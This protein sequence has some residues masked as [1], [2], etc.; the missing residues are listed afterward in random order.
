MIKLGGKLCS[1][2][3]CIEQVQR[4]CT[5]LAAEGFVGIETH[6]CLQRELTVQQK[7]LP[8]LDLTSYKKV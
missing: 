6:E 8:V 2:S 3:P 4:T 7:S 5:K 1:F